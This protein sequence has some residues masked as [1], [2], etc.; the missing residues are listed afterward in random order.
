MPV[1][2]STSL[3]FWTRKPSY[4]SVPIPNLI[5]SPIKVSCDASL[6][7]WGAYITWPDDTHSSIQGHWDST[8]ALEHINIKELRAALFALQFNPEKFA[9]HPVI[10]YS[11]N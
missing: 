6:Q 7:G 11:D 2:I 3:E 4:T 9:D 1:D 10:F 5:R 8:W